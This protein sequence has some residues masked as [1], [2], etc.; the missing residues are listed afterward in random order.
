[1]ND[2]ERCFEAFRMTPVLYEMFNNVRK[3]AC[4][5]F[6]KGTRFPYFQR[7]VFTDDKRNDWT[8]LL[9]CPSKTD[10]KKKRFYVT[11]YTIYEV[12]RKRKEEDVNC[13]KGVLMFDPIAMQNKIDGRPNT[14]AIVYEIVPHAFNRYTERYLKPKGLDGMEFK[15]KVENILSRWQHFDISADLHGDKNAEKHAKD[16][17]MPYDVIMRGGGMLRGFIVDE[18]LIRFKTYV[19]DD[20]MFDNQKERQA[21]MVREHYEWKRLGIKDKR[22]V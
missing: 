1:M 3:E 5:R 8:L 15:R 22:N 7:Y 18:L 11:A 9:W 14:G 16:G 12:Q 2:E 20:Q 21:E 13:G 10:K 17:L 19:A 4:D 6:H